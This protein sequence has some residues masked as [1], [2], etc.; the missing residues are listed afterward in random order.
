MQLSNGLA[1]ACAH[2]KPVISLNPNNPPSNPKPISS[3]SK[4]HFLCVFEVFGCYL[5][6]QPDPPA[7]LNRGTCVCAILGSPEEL[8]QR[9]LCDAVEASKPEKCLELLHAMLADFF[10]PLPSGSVGVD[11][12]W[13]R[14]YSGWVLQKILGW[15]KNMFEGTWQLGPSI[16]P[17]S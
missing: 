1:V 7:K 3:C 4:Q 12:R 8:L 13:I 5:P 11:R 10:S 9:W 14:I 2:P 15:M 16:H 17:V 6:K